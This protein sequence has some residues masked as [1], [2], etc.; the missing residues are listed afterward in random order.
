[1]ILNNLCNSKCNVLLMIGRLD[2]KEAT[3]TE[4]DICNE[5][6][7][8][9]ILHDHVIEA[10]IYFVGPK[11]VGESAVKPLE[12]YDSNV[13]DTLKLVP[14][15]HTAGVKNFI[16]SSSATIYGDQLKIPYVESFPTGTPQNPYGK[17]GLVVERILTD[18]Q[19]VQLEWNVVLLRYFNPVSTHLSSDM[20]E[21][22]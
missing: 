13:T 21:D 3:F 12:Y 1:M 5:T 8:T 2:G 16:F 18:L 4:G 15:M 22:P 20:G 17:S 14:V 19:K 6:L 7:M 10:M 11:A 9:K